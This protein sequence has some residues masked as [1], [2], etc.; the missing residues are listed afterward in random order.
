MIYRNKPHFTIKKNL[1]K[2]KQTGVYFSDVVTL[3]IL[4]DVCQRI[5]GKNSFTYAYVD[6]DYQDEFLE[7]GYN[8]GRLATLQYL[9]EVSYVTFS[10][11]EIGG[12]NSSV[13]SVPTAFNIFYMNPYPKKKLYYYFLNIEGNAGT[14]YQ[15]LMYRLMKTIGFNFI[16]ASSAIGQSLTSFSSIEDIMYMRRANSS[17]NQSNNS[18][19]ITKSNINQY[20]IYGKTYGANKY[21]TSM[22]CYALSILA[23]PQHS[24]TL[25][26]VLEGDL[27]ELPESS[28]NVIKKMNN[29]TVIP[30]DMQLEKNAFIENDSLRS[31]R[32]IF[33]LLRRLGSKHCALCKC[34]IPE[35]I[36]GAH[37]WPVADIKKV[38]TLTIEQK[39]SHAISGENGIW[40]CENHHKMFDSGLLRINLDGTIGYRN[41]IEHRHIS[42]INEVTTIRQ[43]PEEYLTSGFLAYLNMR[44]EIA[45]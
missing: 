2:S 1:Q 23:Q 10:E 17:R 5:T 36:Q 16:N 12:R 21:E 28:L 24:L 4:K 7:S 29:I 11:R 25:Y 13:Q 32:Y 31:P 34:E 15:I 14:D 20:D 45:V 42:F 44:N 38:Q 3:V 27:R 22:M 30:T 19:Y 37:I 35:L 8:K 6:N 9:D 39:L 33:N 40:L 41:D 43:L 18:T 26:E